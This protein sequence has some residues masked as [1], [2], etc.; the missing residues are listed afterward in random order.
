MTKLRNRRAALRW[1]PRRPK[2][3]AKQP[4]RHAGFAAARCPVPPALRNA[5]EDGSLSRSSATRFSPAAA[6][7]FYIVVPL[8]AAGDDRGRHSLRA[9]ATRTDRLRLRRRADRARHQRGVDVQLREDRRCGAEAGPERRARVP[10]SRRQRARS[11]RR[12]RALIASR[13]R[14]HFDGGADCAVASFRRASS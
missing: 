4:A 11:G 5:P 9:A 13:G 6:V 10:P 2:R 14:Q 1:A 3:A 7:M 12:R 8:I